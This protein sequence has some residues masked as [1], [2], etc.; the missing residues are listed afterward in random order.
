MLTIRLSAL[1]MALAAIF[2]LNSP[3][4]AGEAGKEIFVEYQCV[5]CHSVSAYS[6]SLV[7]VEEEADDWGDEDEQV[8]EPPDLSDVGLKHEKK[9]LSMYLRKKADIDGRKHK[10]RFKGTKEERKTL[11]IWLSTLTKSPAPSTPGSVK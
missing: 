7:K 1:A 11:V 2:L 4:S 3:A 9:F 5:S 6:I 10:K 8:I